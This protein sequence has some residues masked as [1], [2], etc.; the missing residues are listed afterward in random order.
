M[1]IC[2]HAGL[3]PVVNTS[4]NEIIDVCATLKEAKTLYPSATVQL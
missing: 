4:T 1:V 3:Y 2:F